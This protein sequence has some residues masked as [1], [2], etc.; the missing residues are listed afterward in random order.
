MLREDT[1][2]SLLGGET[3]GCNGKVTALL[4]PEMNKFLLR[5]LK[6]SLTCDKCELDSSCEAVWVDW[7]TT[8]PLL[9]SAASN[10][11]IV[12]L[13]WPSTV[14]SPELSRMFVWRQH[15]AHQIVSLL[16]TQLHERFLVFLMTVISSRNELS[17]QV[18]LDSLANYHIERQGPQKIQIEVSIRLLP[19][20]NQAQPVS[21]SSCLSDLMCVGAKSACLLA[22]CQFESRRFEGRKN[23]AHKSSSG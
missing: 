4:W 7:F 12:S 1:R 15:S 2:F 23:K 13:S 10:E 6:R 9:T 19:Q 8:A 20:T 3:G 17:D 16:L 22:G 21:Y 5:G 18:P 14:L 11:L